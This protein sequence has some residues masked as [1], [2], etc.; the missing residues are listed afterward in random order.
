MALPALL[1][2]LAVTKRRS[3]MLA[4]RSPRCVSTLHPIF[5]RWTRSEEHTSELQSLM[6][7][8]YAVFC[9]KNKTATQGAADTLAHDHTTASDR[10]R[11]QR[12]RQKYHTITT[13]K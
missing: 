7:T 8:S 5:W 11:H 10:P 9:L 6:R 12:H 3:A 1:A 13:Q 2:R 4:M